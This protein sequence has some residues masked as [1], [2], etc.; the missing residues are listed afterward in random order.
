MGLGYSWMAYDTVGCPRRQ[1]DDLG[2]SWMS[3]GYNGIGLGYN[4]I[5]WDESRIL[6]DEPR[7]QWDGIKYSR[8]A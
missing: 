3:L 6:W 5:Q 1:L 8:M 7:I 2:Y 4:M